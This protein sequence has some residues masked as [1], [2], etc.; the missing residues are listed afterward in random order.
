[1]SGH[2]SDYKNTI[3]I[4]TVINTISHLNITLVYG[5]KLR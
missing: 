3:P 4:P 1:M 2:S 5:D